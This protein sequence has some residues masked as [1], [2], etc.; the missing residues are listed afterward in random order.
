VDALASKAQAIYAEIGRKLDTSGSGGS[1]ESALAQ[2][3]GIPAVDG[4]GFDGGDFHTDHEWMNVESV[5]PRIYLTARLI[6]E[7][8]RH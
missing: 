2:A 7:V 5:G 1:S 6:Q 8:T 3:A 4:L